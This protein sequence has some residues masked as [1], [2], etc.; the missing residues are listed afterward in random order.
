MIQEKNDAVTEF[1]N[2]ME[3]AIKELAARSFSPIEG[4]MPPL[5]YLE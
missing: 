1:D 5:R 4:T 3:D 2:L